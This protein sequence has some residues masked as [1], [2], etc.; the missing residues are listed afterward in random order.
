[1]K[2]LLKVFLVDDERLIRKHLMNC[3]NW[4]QEG[5]EIVG[6]SS[7]RLDAMDQ[8][9]KLRPDLIF[10]DIN[11]PVINGLDLGKMILDKIPEVKIIMLTGYEDFDFAREALRF[12]AFEYLLKPINPKEIKKVLKEVRSAIEERKSHWDMV[13]SLKKKVSDIGADEKEVP[14]IK[15]DSLVGRVQTFIDENLSDTSLT[16][17][18][19]AEVFYVNASYLSRTF[20]QSVGVSFVEYVNKQRMQKAE[21]LLRYEALKSYEV[22]A[23]VG[24]EDPHYFG[25]LFK[26][27]AGMTVSEYKNRLKK[28]Q[29]SL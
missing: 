12:G 23:K 25:L 13:D 11:M 18:K 3:I 8:I 22:A 17:K 4:E 16:Q 29:D 2:D 26:K 21:E 1:M 9:M 20:K 27:H 28:G 19:T 5:F 24:I 10:L 7:G 6:E 15:P 14:K